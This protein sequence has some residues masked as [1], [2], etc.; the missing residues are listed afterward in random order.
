ML[1]SQRQ[2]VDQ[3]DAANFFNAK[4]SL[5]A[6]MMSELKKQSEKNQEKTNKPNPPI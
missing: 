5:C 1:T 4:V 6:A 2:R 3:R